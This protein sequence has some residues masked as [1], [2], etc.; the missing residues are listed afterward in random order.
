M[1][2]SIFLP[3]EAFTRSESVDVSQ[4]VAGARCLPLVI[5][6]PCPAKSLPAV[7]RSMPPC[8]SPARAACPW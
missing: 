2:A 5:V 1:F 4:P 6:I 8:L 7:S 3:G